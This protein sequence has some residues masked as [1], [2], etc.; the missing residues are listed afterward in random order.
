MQSGPS[1]APAVRLSEDLVH[2]VQDQDQLR[3]AL[4][5][6]L[7][8]GERDLDLVLVEPPQGTLQC[9]FSGRAMG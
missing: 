3:L 9:P 7:R 5:I 2:D 1:K 4:G 8:E 6:L